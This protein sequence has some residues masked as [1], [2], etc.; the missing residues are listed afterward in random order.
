MDRLAKLALAKKLTR[1]DVSELLTALPAHVNLR[2]TMHGGVKAFKLDKRLMTGIHRH[3]QTRVYPNVRRHRKDPRMR[4]AKSLASSK[5]H[6]THVHRVTHQLLKRVV[7][8][9]GDAARA[10]AGETT[11]DAEVVRMLCQDIADFGWVVVGTEALAV[12]EMSGCATQ[13]DVVC[14]ER[15]NPCNLVAVEL[16]TGYAF[17]HDKV[18]ARDGALRLGR[19][20]RG[21]LK[22]TPHTRHCLQAFI[23]GRMLQKMY[24][25]FGINVTSSRV[26]YM[27]KHKRTGALKDKQ[28]CWMPCPVTALPAKDVNAIVEHVLC[29]CTAAR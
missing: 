3:L 2:L 11:K 1:A 15:N 19:K 4:A 22:N 7:A 9:N 24:Q 6:G 26:V 28:L 27:D 29:P 21:K 13:V 5:R 17:G 25:L 10:L 23:G 12:H 20:L 16:K 14:A 18:H 8:F